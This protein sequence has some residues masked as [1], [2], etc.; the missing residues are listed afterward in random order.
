MRRKSNFKNEGRN[1]QKRQSDKNRQKL[2]FAIAQSIRNRIDQ[3]ESTRRSIFK[4]CDFSQFGISKPK[5]SIFI[6][7][8]RIGNQKSK[9]PDELPKNNM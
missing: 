1:L 8:C 9:S 5:N 2:I 3:F 6:K 4:K 7:K